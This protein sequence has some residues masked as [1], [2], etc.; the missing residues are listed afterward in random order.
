MTK[1]NRLYYQSL[2]EKT[3]K[4][5]RRCQ[6]KLKHKPLLNIKHI[7][8]TTEGK[9]RWKDEP[10]EKLKCVRCNLNVSAYNRTYL[11]PLEIYLN[12]GV[13]FSWNQLFLIA[14]PFFSREMHFNKRLTK[15][16]TCLD[17]FIHI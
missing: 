14:Y 4:Q 11:K 1:M 7:S 2:T 13:H 10:C 9:L 6:K 3:K 8:N 15:T 5:I 12:V 16:F 17:P